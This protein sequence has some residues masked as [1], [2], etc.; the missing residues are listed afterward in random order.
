M[1]R[2]VDIQFISEGS[3][4]AC[5]NDSN[6]VSLFHTRMSALELLSE[7]SRRG[8]EIYEQK[9]PTSFFSFLGF[10]NLNLYNEYPF[11]FF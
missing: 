9:N 11:S 10:L 8:Y 2:I 1:A 6:E 7:S 5:L 4:I 3:Q